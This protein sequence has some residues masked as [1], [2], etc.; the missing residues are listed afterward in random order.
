[1]AFLFLWQERSL[2]MQILCCSQAFIHTLI[3]LQSIQASCA[4]TRR[5][6]L[7]GRSIM[8]STC[9]FILPSPPTPLYLHLATS[10]MWCW[11]GGSGILCTIIMVHKGMF[12]TTYE[13]DI[14]KTKELMWI[15]ICTNS[16]WDKGVKLSTLGFRTSKINVTWC[17][18]KYVT[19]IPCGKISQQPCNK[20]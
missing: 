16:V 13:D 14:L 19:E 4:S 6:R 15:Q 7:A 11:S 18:P 10:E 8:L 1:M 17:Q 20:C 9:P 3:M 2:L 12:I 5:A